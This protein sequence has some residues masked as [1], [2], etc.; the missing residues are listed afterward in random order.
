[1]S[2]CKGHLNPQ[3]VQFGLRKSNEVLQKG[4]TPGKFSH[5]LRILTKFGS[6][7]PHN[8]QERADASAMFSRHLTPY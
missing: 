2:H 3:F 4:F 8:I 5:N 7:A 1:M 6:N